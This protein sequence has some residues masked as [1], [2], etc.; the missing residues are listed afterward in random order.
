MKRIT[1]I[2]FS[3]E[4]NWNQ[5]RFRSIGLVTTLVDKL[6]TL[7]DELKKLL[8]ESQVTEFKWKNLA[9]A[10]ER[11]AA[12]KLVAFAVEKAS[13]RKVRIDV[14]IWDIEDS[15]HK[16]A[17]RDDIDN[18]A[19]MYYH[20]FRNVLRKRWPEDAV[21]RLCPDEH[22]AIKW[23]TIQDVLENA[24]MSVE[25]EETLFTEGGFKRRLKRELSI[26]A[27]E[28][29]NSSKEPLL[30]LADLFAGLAVFSREKFDGYQQWVSKKSP[31]LRLLDESEQEE[32]ISRSNKERFQVLEECDKK[33]KKYKLG[34]SMK[35]SKGLRTRDP[36]SPI[37]FWVYEPQHPDDKA[38]TRR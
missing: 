24:S 31:Q 28:P 2:G 17:G 11:F 32:S 30:Q 14:L 37:N 7:N 16:V 8:E 38:P 13:A 23:D 6:T 12:N 10:R 26:D 22:T 5:G 36:K 18:L 33:C 3:D 1:H 9:G 25:L 15:R 20:L 19:R 29:V 35:S 34:V 4:S 21:W 27:I